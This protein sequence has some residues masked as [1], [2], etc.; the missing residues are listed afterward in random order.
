VDITV[1]EDGRPEMVVIPRWT[2]ANPEKT[3]RLQAFGGFLSEF[4]EFDGYK[5][6]TRVEGGNLIGTE[7][8]FPFYKVSVDRLRFPQAGDQGDPLNHR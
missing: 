3:F 5:L 4:R 8:Y 6:P 7:A 1:A 2:D